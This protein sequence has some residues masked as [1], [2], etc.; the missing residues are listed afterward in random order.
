M[1]KCSYLGVTVDADPELTDDEVRHCV[2]TEIDN[3]NQQGKKLGAVT[4]T[5]EGEEI[6]IQA[7]E[8]S[9]I[10]R[11]R[12]ITGYLTNQSNMNESK[13]AEE[14]ARYKHVGGQSAA[15]E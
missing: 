14:A 6:E 12:R 3:W 10:R 2:I 15:R 9:P 4:L 7:T 11:I 5:A 1:R 8:W 13:R